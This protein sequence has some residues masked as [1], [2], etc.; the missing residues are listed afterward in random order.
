MRNYWISDSDLPTPDDKHKFY[1]IEINVN[2]VECA[3]LG[4]D[5]NKGPGPDGITPANLKWLASFI[6]AP[7][8]FVFKLSLSAGVFPATWKEFS[9]VSVEYQSCRTFRKNSKKWS[10]V[11]PVI[12]D[13]Q[14]GFVMGCSTVSNLVQFTNGVIGEI[15]DEW[16]V[17]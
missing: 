17:N 3:F 15:E 7:L 1:T 4:L 14:H 9:V 8:T 2:E 6:K 10:V 13:E 16:Q 12:S 5:V 11:R